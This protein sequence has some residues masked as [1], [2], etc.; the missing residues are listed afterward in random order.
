MKLTDLKRDHLKKKRQNIN[1]QNKFS[2]ILYKKS[3]APKQ[4]CENTV[5]DITRSIFLNLFIPFF[6]DL[7]VSNSVIA[8]I[9]Q[10]YVTI[11]YL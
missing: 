2:Q 11:L 3:A 6:C 1:F 9:Y 8:W 4:V 10:F 5:N 7:Y